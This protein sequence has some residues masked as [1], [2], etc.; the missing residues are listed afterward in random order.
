MMIWMMSHFNDLDKLQKKAFIDNERR[1]AT[2]TM[3]IDNHIHDSIKAYLTW[4]PI[5]KISY[6]EFVDYYKKH[7]LHNIEMVIKP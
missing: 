6:P 1:L 7:G 4:L 2:L 3:M 5:F